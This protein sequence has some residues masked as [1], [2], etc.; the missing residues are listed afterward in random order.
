MLTAPAENVVPATVDIC[1][2]VKTDANATLPPAIDAVFVVT[3][4]PTAENAQMLFVESTS[5][6]VAM[7]LCA[8]PELLAACSKKLVDILVGVAGVYA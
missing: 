5:I 2:C 4:P 1:N 8:L 7:P 6:S 3:P